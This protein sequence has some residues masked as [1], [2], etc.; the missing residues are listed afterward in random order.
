MSCEVL[1]CEVNS[2]IDAVVEAKGGALMEQLFS[3]ITSPEPAS[4]RLAGY[5]E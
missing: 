3:V 1:C 5:F 2:L 4:D